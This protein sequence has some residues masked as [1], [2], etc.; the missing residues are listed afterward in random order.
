MIFS[1]VRSGE[2]TRSQVLGY[3]LASGAS[4]P[5][6]ACLVSIAAV[7]QHHNLMDAAYPNCWVAQLRPSS[8]WS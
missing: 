5:D 2:A 7:T 3:D 4:R 1:M 6:S 8:S